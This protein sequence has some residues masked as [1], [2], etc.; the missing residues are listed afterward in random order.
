[1]DDYKDLLLKALSLKL[2]NYEETPDENNNIF[3]LNPRHYLNQNKEN[4]NEINNENNNNKEMLRSR[5]FQKLACGG[6]GLE[7]PRNFSRGDH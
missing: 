6:L 2:N 7:W 5:N 1:M 3:N 4:E